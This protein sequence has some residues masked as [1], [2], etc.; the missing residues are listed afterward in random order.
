MN[1]ARSKSSAF[2]VKVD[3]S[4]LDRTSRSFTGPLAVRFGSTWFPEKSWTDFPIVVIGWWLDA[5]ESLKSGNDAVFH[6]MDGPFQFNARQVGNGRIALE[7]VERH[8]DDS[9]RIAQTTVPASLVIQTI[10]SAAREILAACK[11]KKWSD[12]DILQLQAMLERIM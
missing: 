10:V 4:R 2:S 11:R 1:S 12:S 7:S 5:C 9:S 8:G 3:P 6:F